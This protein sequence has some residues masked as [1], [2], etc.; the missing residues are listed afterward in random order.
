MIKVI[1][2]VSLLI[3]PLVVQVAEAIKDKGWLSVDVLPYAVI[4]IIGAA[5]MYWAIMYS[6]KESFKIENTGK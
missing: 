2:M 6:R 5:I 3:V 1:N 4:A